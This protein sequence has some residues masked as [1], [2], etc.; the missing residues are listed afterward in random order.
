MTMTPTVLAQALIVPPPSVTTP[1]LT[2]LG[3]FLFFVGVLL[4]ATG[5]TA[6]VAFGAAFRRG[7]ELTV[8]HVRIGLVAFAAILTGTAAA[9]GGWLLV[10]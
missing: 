1:V 5:I 3:Y 4:A 7:G 9:W 6:G 10:T 8:G 2:L